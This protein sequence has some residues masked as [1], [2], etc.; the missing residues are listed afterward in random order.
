MK[1]WYKLR[2]RKKIKY[3][4]ISY[5]TG[6]H[7]HKL[8]ILKELERKT[9][10]SWNYSRSV[11]CWSNLLY[12]STLLP[13]QDTITCTHTTQKV[14]FYENHT[15]SD[16]TVCRHYEF[17][18]TRLSHTHDGS[19]GGLISAATFTAHIRSMC[20][21]YGLLRCLVGRGLRSHCRYALPIVG[22]DLSSPLTDYS[23]T[24]PR[25]KFISGATY[26]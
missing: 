1:L 5:V 7:V 23:M 26:I 18:F 14:S 22:T 15:M 8:T 4:G 17:S 6:E 3:I 19:T 25:T 16:L 24:K 13:L 10:H 9:T 12:R 11:Y 20:T 21:T 2:V